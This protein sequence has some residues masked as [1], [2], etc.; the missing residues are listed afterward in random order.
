MTTTLRPRLPFDLAVLARSHGW[1]DLPPFSWDEGDRTLRYRALVDGRSLAL[2]LRQA[3][4]DG[5]I[6]VSSPSAALELDEGA[7]SVVRRILSLDSDL[8]PTWEL[9]RREP[10]LRWAAD[11]GA[12]RMLRS[13]TLFEDLLKILF[14][15]NCTWAATRSMCQNAMALGVAG[16]FPSP[17]ELDDLEE[18]D[19]KS[20]A[21]VGYRARSA[22]ELVRRFESDRGQIERELSRMSS[23]ELSKW[24]LALPGFG[25]YAA[26]QA[27]RLLGRFESLALD[28]WCRSRIAE[29]TG[30]ERSDEA[31]EKVYGEYGDSKGLILWLDITRDWHE[32]EGADAHRAELGQKF[33]RRK[34]AR[35]SK[36]GARG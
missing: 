28:S 31:I 2:V 33:S 11:R 19:W 24:L 26:G 10:R 15:T 14:T 29:L 23:A 17:S 5:P 16:A 21:R 25:P 30:R 27:M 4:P 6:E 1:Y 35:A 36:G 7:M 18:S 12:G 32:R 8:E 22:K 13:A 20:K 3:A 9:A 34:R